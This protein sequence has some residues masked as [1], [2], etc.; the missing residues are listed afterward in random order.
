MAAGNDV[1]HPIPRVSPRGRRG[2]ERYDVVFYRPW[3]GA[4]LASHDSMPPGGAETQV[5]MLARALVRRGLRV[6]IVVF[7]VAGELTREVEGVR[8]VQREPYRHP[9][10]VAEKLAEIARLWRSLART[11]S[12][13]I[14]YMTAAM[15][16]GLIG[17]YARATRR[18]LVFA[19]GS[20]ADFDLDSRK[21]GRRRLHLLGYRLG[22]HLASRI[23]V[24]TEEQ[25]D[26]C[27]RTFRRR[28]RVIG[29]LAPLEEPQT[30]AAEAFLWIGRLASYKRPFEYIELARA[31]PEARF[32]M[33][34]VPSPLPHGNGQQLAQEVDQRASEVP[35]LELLPPRSHEEI[36]QLM[37]RAVASVNTAE[38][39]GMPN[40]LL[41][42]W[43]RGV[44][45]LVLNHD[46]GGVIETHGLGGFAAGSRALLAG[47]AREQWRSRFDRE[48]ISQ[49]CRAYI[50]AH[51]SPDTVAE[52]WAQVVAVR[53]APAQGPLPPRWSRHVWH[54]RQ[55]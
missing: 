44:P 55:S 41:E 43:S 48:D 32:W 26:L 2:A 27:R 31:V 50:E 45:A 19:T 39:E 42:A 54:S 30:K 35:N 40:T 11:P 6:A 47:L 38:F 34:G 1:D 46:P 24:Q 33:V 15:E 10:T 20:I 28:P 4:I 5:L 17:I 37:A 3:V 49:R 13:S 51:H 14:V 8:I 29:S 36:G 9:R 22:A 21:P 18:Q 53:P 12:G 52:E 25:V 7:G 23:V 16:L